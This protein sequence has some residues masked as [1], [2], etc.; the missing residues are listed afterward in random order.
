MTVEIERKFLVT[1]PPDLNR[2]SSSRIEQG[3]LT[4]VEHGAEVRLRRRDGELTLTVKGGSDRDRIEV[5][6]PVSSE[7]FDE[8]WPLTADRRLVKVRYLVPV[9]DLTAELDRY[10][11]D[12]DGLQVAEVEFDSAAVADSF[13]P[14]GWFGD[15][16]TGDERYLNE[17]LALEGRP[18]V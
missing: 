5:E 15:E 10:E 3:Y 6:L 17:R 2:F 12:L 13:E 4:L 9:D 1:Q 14:P 7:Q 11:G 8:L 16:V 18:D